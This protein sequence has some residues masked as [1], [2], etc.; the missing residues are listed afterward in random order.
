MTNLKTK[1]I[2]KTGLH[3]RMVPRLA[4]HTDTSA[5]SHIVK[6]VNKGIKDNTEESGFLIFDLGINEYARKLRSPNRYSFVVEGPS[7]AAIGFILCMDRQGVE[8]DLQNGQLGYEK[9]ILSIPFDKAGGENFIWGD[10]MAVFPPPERRSGVGRSLLENVFQAMREANIKHFFGMI[11]LHPHTN[12][13]GLNFLIK[14]DVILI[15]ARAFRGMKWGVVYH[16]VY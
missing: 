14:S 10:Q 11:A 5:I 6:Q 15:G 8:A 3:P 13:A 2:M 1:N 16:E 12:I 9:D 7:G 4:Q